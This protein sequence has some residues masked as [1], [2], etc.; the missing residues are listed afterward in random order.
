MAGYP[1]SML[2]FQIYVPTKE[3]TLV[4]DPNEPTKLNYRRNGIIS[5]CVAFLQKKPEVHWRRSLGKRSVRNN[6]AYQCDN[7]FWKN[8]YHKDTLP[9]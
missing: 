9:W 8:P 4:I 1:W 7:R 3:E 5:D 6:R 2:G